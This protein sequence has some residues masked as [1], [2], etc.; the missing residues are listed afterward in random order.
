MGLMIFAFAVIFG[1]LSGWIGALS[2]AGMRGVLAIGLGALVSASAMAVFMFVQVG[3]LNLLGGNK[4]FDEVLLTAVVLA[5]SLCFV[6]GPAFAVF[7]W[8]TGKVGL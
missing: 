5:G 3:L 6:W 8:R 4:G 7:Y 1:V 2:V